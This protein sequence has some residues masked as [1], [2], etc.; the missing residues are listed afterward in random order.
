M[1]EQC[2]GR[3]NKRRLK[4]IWMTRGVGC[5]WVEQVREGVTLAHCLKQLLTS[6]CFILDDAFFTKRELKKIPKL[7]AESVAR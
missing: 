2:Q 3:D 5:C 6:E 4:H 1:P 7:Q